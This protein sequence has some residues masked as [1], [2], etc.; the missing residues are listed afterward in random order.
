MLVG[1]SLNTLAVRVVL[2]F[3]RL[4]HEALWL[5]SIVGRFGE[6][7]SLKPCDTALFF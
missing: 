1:R 7:I 4:A 2:F 3:H 6:T 5:S